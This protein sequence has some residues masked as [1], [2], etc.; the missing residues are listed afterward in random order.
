[1]AVFDIADGAA[2][3]GSISEIAFNLNGAET[4]VI[5]VGGLD[6]DVAENFIG[7]IG[8]QIAGVAIWNFY[9]A[10]SLDVDRAF[11]GSILAPYAQLRNMNALNGSVVAHSMTQRG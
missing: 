7:G 4:I 2:F 9:E 5:N 3:F 6:L 10:V 11:F 1:L 8:A